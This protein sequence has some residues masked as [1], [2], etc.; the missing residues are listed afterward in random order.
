V[1]IL[2]R[3]LPDVNLGEAECECKGL[4]SWEWRVE[5]LGQH[6]GKDLISK[7]I[8]GLLGGAFQVVRGGSCAVGLALRFLSFSI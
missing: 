6:Y 3:Y 5:V 7:G 1:L 4:R 2:L 8:A